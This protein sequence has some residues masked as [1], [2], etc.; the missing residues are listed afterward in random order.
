MPTGPELNDDWKYR[1]MRMALQGLA[2][3]VGTG[4]ASSAAVTI[5]DL[6]GL[7]TT[8]ALTTAQNAIA[9]VTL[10][11]D[12]V[13]V[14]DL[15]FWSIGDGTNT[16]GTPMC[17]QATVSANTVVFEIANKHASAE[18]FNGTL[19]IRFMIVKAL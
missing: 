9:T 7:I 8:E 13:A 5:N 2:T 4:T 12:K 14:G 18:A 10:T 16:Q 11:N 6:F 19:L 17:M 3:E 15:V 1:N